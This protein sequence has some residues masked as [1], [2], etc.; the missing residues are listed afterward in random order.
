MIAGLLPQHP[1]GLHACRSIT[2]LPGGLRLKP[3]MENLLLEGA[4]PR[5]T[6]EALVLYLCS[7]KT[8]GCDRI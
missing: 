3:F 4:D 5:L 7:A 6:P 2:G 8:D 1:M